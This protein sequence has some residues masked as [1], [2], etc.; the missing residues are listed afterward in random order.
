M[1]NHLCC[2][3]LLEKVV[4]ILKASLYVLY[5]QEHQCTLIIPRKRTQQKNS[6]K[7]FKMGHDFENKTEFTETSHCYQQLRWGYMHFNK[8]EKSKHDKKFKRKT[9]STINFTTNTIYTKSQF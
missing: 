7:T 1:L 5:I 6:I 4:T 9:L 8:Q 3:R 2:K